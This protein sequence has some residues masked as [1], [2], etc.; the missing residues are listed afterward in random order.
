MISSFKI[1]LCCS[2]YFAIISASNLFP[3]KN[4]TINWP[5]PRFE[6]ITIKDGLPENS[7]QCMLQDHLGFLWLGTQSGLVKYD[8]YTMKVFLPD[9]DDSFSISDRMFLSFY[10]DKSGN[11]WI[12]TWDG[13][14]NLFNRSTETFV[15]YMHKPDDSTSIDNNRVFCINETPNGNLLIGTPEGLNLFDNKNKVF[16]HIYFR[17]LSDTMSVRSIITDRLTGNIYVCSG[18][19]IFIYNDEKENLVQISNNTVLKKELGEINSLYQ[20]ADGTIW[21]A[22]SQG[23]ARFNSLTGNIKN[24][25]PSL[26]GLDFNV[27]SLENVIEDGD[28]FIWAATSSSELIWFDPRQEKFKKYLYDPENPLSLSCDCTS[29]LYK[30]R[31]G[32]IWVCNMESGLYKWDIKKISLNFIAMILIIPKVVVSTR[33]LL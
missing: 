10:E 32:I 11:L 23:L 1:F 20:A 33:S 2:L 3:Q 28:G 31:T 15:R 19:K 18:S 13:G 17:N 14:L 6:Q 24:Y 30:D 7:V 5:E 8:G 27:N 26:M 25:Q 29:S 22:H 16:R 21:I 4:Q 9:P 12:G